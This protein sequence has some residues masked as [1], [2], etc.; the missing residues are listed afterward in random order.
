MNKQAKKPQVQEKKAT[1]APKNAA[2][3]FPFTS[4][5]YK[6]M[7]IGIFV[8]FVGFILMSGGGTN[9]PTEFAGDT[10]FS[11]RRMTLAPVMVLA[12]F[13]VVLWAIIKTP[14][15]EHPNQ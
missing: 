2:D 6:W 11:F 5:N 10:L 4:D 15:E 12:G 3:A 8:A 9:D 13:A 1:P 14:K 7:I